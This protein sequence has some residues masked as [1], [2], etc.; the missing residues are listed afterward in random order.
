MEKQNELWIVLQ[1]KSGAE[2]NGNTRHLENCYRQMPDVMQLVVLLHCYDGFSESKIAKL[3]GC[4]KELISK[5]VRTA[6]LRFSMECGQTVSPVDLKQMLTELIEAYCV[7]A[8]LEERVKNAL[9]R[10]TEDSF[11]EL[12]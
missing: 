6:C 8:E 2:K 7:P 12:A 5:C 1:L 9:L 11:S 4:R 3:I 10:M